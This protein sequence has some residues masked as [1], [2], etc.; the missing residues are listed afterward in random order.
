MPQ[1][2]TC[3]AVVLH[4]FGTDDHCGTALYSVLATLCTHVHAETSAAAGMPVQ[5]TAAGGVLSVVITC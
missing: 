2:L 5:H 3:S 1:R 4:M